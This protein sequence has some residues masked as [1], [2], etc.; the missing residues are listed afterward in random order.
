MTRFC[1][2]QAIAMSADWS[3][4]AGLNISILR[5]STRAWVRDQSAL[6]GFWERSGNGRRFCVLC[7]RAKCG[8]RRKGMV[9]IEGTLLIVNG[10]NGKAEL[11]HFYV[12]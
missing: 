9:A 2:V 4:P 10:T 7:L 6:E 8:C 11:S 1:T 12:W 3:S 5:T